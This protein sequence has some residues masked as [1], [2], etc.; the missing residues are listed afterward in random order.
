MKIRLIQFYFRFGGMLLPMLMAKKALHLF[1]TPKRRTYLKDKSAAIYA[2]AAKKELVINNSH[3][4]VYTWGTGV[5]QAVLALNNNSKIKVRKLLL[6]A[7]PADLKEVMNRFVSM[8]HLPLKSIKLLD[9]LIDN[10]VG[11]TMGEL[12]RNLMIKPKNVEEIKMIHDVND[13][14]VPII[15]VERVSKLWGVSVL[16]TKGLSHNKVIKDLGVIQKYVLN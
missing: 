11:K 13:E 5:K 6:F 1:S 15:D 3:L 7:F 12:D 16:E 4:A 14:V 9:Q 10:R 2:L 8:I